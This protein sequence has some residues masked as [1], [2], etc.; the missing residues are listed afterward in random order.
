MYA[1]PRIVARF[2]REGVA[3]TRL[4]GP[5][6]VT[7]YELGEDADG[8][9]FLVMELLRGDTLLARFRARQRLP[10]REVVAVAREVCDSLAEAHGMGIVHRDLKPGNIF[11][12]SRPDGSELVK[13]LD[14]GIA[15]LLDG[16]DIEGGGDDLTKNNEVVGTFEYISPEQV[17]GTEYSGRSDIYTLGVVMYEMIVGQRPF[18]DFAGPAL[19]VAILEERPPVPSAHLAGLPAALDRVIVRCLEP[20]PAARYADV[21]ELAAA[22]DELAARGPIETPDI[23]DEMTNILAR[24]PVAPSPP[25]PL[26]PL[27]PLPPPRGLPYATP[28]PMAAVKAPPES[29]FV[30]AYPTLEGWVAPPRPAIPP[31]PQVAPPQASGRLWLLLVL[32]GAISLGV[33]LALLL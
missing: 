18:A 2:K 1:D 20:D 32:A 9:L 25:P 29:P 24:P 10:W 30:S 21:G 14:F 28:M 11:L 27:P 23:A 5:H 16:S 33:L 4:R 12:A 19:M 8:T 13:V 15:K 17:R 3:L 7:T 26:L 31:P 6:T 22:L